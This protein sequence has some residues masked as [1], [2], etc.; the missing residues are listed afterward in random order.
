M[1]NSQGSFSYPISHSCLVMGWIGMGKY[2]QNFEGC[3]VLVSLKENEYKGI[4][5]SLYHLCG[6]EIFS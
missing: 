3:I 6:Y 5:K 4:F 2:R 1:R